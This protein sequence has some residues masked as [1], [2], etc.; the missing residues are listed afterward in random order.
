MSINIVTIEH[1]EISCLCMKQLLQAGMT[2]NSAIRHLEFLANN[3]A[4]YRHLGKLS[5][6]HAD[7][8]KIWSKSALLAKKHSPDKKYRE[9]LRIEHGT[10]RRRFAR[11][12]YDQFLK[13]S[14]TEK[15]MNQHCDSKWKVAVITLDEDKELNKLAKREFNSPDERWE[16]AGIKF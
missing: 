11:T 8:Y 5:P 9:F 3:Y 10:P 16:A 12:I 13:G 4:K 7:E 14:L 15:W 2:E 1:L 6:D